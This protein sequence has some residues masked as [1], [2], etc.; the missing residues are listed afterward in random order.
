MRGTR[1]FRSWLG[2]LIAVVTLPAALLG[3]PAGAATPV[4]FASGP[5]APAPADA[6]TWLAA[7]DGGVFS[8]GGAPFYGSMGGKRLNRPI[9]TM[10]ATPTGRGYWLV[11]SDGGIFAFGEAPFRG[12]MGAQKLAK[13]V[14]GMVRYADGYLMVGADGGIFDFSSAPFLGSLGDHPAPAPIVAVAAI[15]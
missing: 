15:G 5:G 13:P 6:G 9:V 7:S 1:F 8:F 12:S 14:V 2:A 10:A 4:P 3:G 11:A